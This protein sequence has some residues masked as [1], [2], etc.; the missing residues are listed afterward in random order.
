MFVG[1]RFCE[2]I[3]RSFSPHACT[4]KWHIHTLRECGIRSVSVLLVALD[5]FSQSV[6][7][8]AMALSSGRSR[9][10]STEAA[11]LVRHGS[12]E[13]IVRLIEPP[14]LP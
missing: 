14:F 4:G 11:W 3:L 8:A 7:H 1:E 2:R 12:P 5:L 6:Y 9:H 10:L 13:Y